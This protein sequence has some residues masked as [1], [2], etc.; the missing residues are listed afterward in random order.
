MDKSLRPPE[1]I[2]GLPYSSKADV[3][4]LGC[5]VGFILFPI[6]YYLILIIVPD[7]SFV[8]WKTSRS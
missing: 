5:T 1:V 6:H 7:L 4:I 3:W 2:L 8:D